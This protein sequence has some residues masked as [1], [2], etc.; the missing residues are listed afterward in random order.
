MYCWPTFNGE[1]LAW[2]D[3]RR[4]LFAPKGRVRPMVAFKVLV[5]GIVARGE[6]ELGAGH[7]PIVAE[8]MCG[9]RA[10]ARFDRPTLLLPCMNAKWGRQVLPRGVPTTPGARAAAR[11]LGILCRHC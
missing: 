4:L 2:D 11:P 6:V 1:F 7:S 3:H 5:F 10:R 9:S 8:A